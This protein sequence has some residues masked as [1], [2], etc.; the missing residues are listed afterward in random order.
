MAQKSVSH[1]ADEAVQA[2]NAV[3]I[4]TPILEIEPED[5]TL[6][7]L[8]NRVSN[9]DAPGLPIY[10]DLRDS[11]DAPLPTDTTLILRAVRPTDDDPTAV[12]V[13][14]KH[15]APWND[16]TTAEQR[17]ED[18]IDSVKIELVGD[19]VNIRDKDVL[20]VDIESSAEIDWSNSEF[21][22]AREGVEEHPFE[23]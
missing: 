6:L 13:A 9:G 11:N 5:G 18:N 19:R 21:Y 7:R 10:A 12:S 14:E 17:D 15:I 8:L 22:F 4:L 20:R 1:L 3:G 2:T 16:L 23:G